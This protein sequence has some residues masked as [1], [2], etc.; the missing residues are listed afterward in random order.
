LVV[1]LVWLVLTVSPCHST[2]IVAI[3]TPEVVALAA[4]TAATFKGG[5]QPDTQ[6]TVSK[7]GRHG[8]VLYALSGFVKDPRGLFDPATTIAAS[9]H[10]A[11]P[12]LSVVAQIEAQLAHALT[13]ALLHL[14]TDDPGLFRQAITAGTGGTTVLLA[15]FEHGA[16]VAISLTFRGAATATGHLR[17]HTQ[18]RTCPGAD[19]P[20]GRYTFMRGRHKAIE[21]YFATHSPRLAM[22]P[23]DAVRF[24]VQLE[25]DA[26]TPGVGPPI[27][28]VRL[29]QD[30]IHWLA[31]L[32][33]R[34][35]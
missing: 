25:I 7:I 28:V 35:P 32:G 23:E 14:R 5:G 4:D 29:S 6:A 13:A 16:P 17:I 19:C 26:K 10:E 20:E 8:Q 33:T 24:L 3:R 1:S 9:F 21:Q 12:F 11:Q 34:A 18:R 30:G 2:T 15:S 27:E 22:R 31:R